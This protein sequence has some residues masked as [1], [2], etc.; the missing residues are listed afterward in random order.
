LVNSFLPRG[1]N[2]L[3]QISKSKMDTSDLGVSILNIVNEQNKSIKK[4]R[5]IVD[6]RQRLNPGVEKS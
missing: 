1:K 5:N 2:G 3:K 4:I 6:K